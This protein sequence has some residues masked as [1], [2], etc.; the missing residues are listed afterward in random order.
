M[1]KRNIVNLLLLGAASLPIGGLALPYA[2]FFVPPRR[3]CRGGL[4]GSGKWL[5]PPTLVTLPRDGDGGRGRRASAG[6][7]AG[8]RV[9][10]CRPRPPR[11]AMGAKRAP[12]A[13][14]RSFHRDAHPGRPRRGRSRPALADHLPPPP[15]R[16]SGGGGGALPAKDA[17]GNDVKKSAWLKTHQKGD[18][19]LV[20]GLKGDPAY[21]IVT[22]EGNLEEYGLNAVCTHLGCVVPWVASANQFQ[23][24]CHGSRYNNEGKVVRGP[25]P[26]SLA[27]S[28]VSV[29]DDSVFLSPWTEVRRPATRQPRRLGS[30]PTATAGVSTGVT[31]DERRPLPSSD[32]AVVGAGM[33]RERV[34]SADGLPHGPGAL[35]GVSGRVRDARHARGGIRHA[36][37]PCA[38][39]GLDG[40]GVHGPPAPR[41]PGPP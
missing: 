12:S 8:A 10:A 30:L 4:A 28:H 39:V 25:A 40:T 9:L 2:V 37:S 21:L 36:A 18:R 19:S 41:S 35:V 1:N 13:M 11:G 14:M 26:L 15:V 27:L 29:T 3:V 20:Q 5:S 32:N 38:R 24:P 31:S 23:C 16:S 17:L 22:N 6:L 7:V 34:L 33:T